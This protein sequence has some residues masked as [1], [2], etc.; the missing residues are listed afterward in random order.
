MA[1]LAV[2]LDFS[3]GVVAV[4]VAVVELEEPVEG[5]EDIDCGKTFTVMMSWLLFDFVTFWPEH[6]IPHRSKTKGQDI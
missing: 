6:I 3:L 2:G 5:S 4:G 1:D